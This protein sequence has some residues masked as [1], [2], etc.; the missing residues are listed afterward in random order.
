MTKT[1][2]SANDTPALLAD[3]C[4]RA[5]RYL[6]DIKT[7]RVFPLEKDIAALARLWGPMPMHPEDPRNILALLDE[8]GSPATAASNAGRYFGFVNGAALPV[9]LAAQS[10]A[11]AWDQNAALRIMS[12]AAAVLEDVALSWLIDLFCLPPHCGAALVSGA[13]SANFTGLARWR[14]RL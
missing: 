7:R 6:N 1:I 2:Q 10:L 12:P 9:C 5:T 4:S 14:A 11:A 8:V 13:A 3:A